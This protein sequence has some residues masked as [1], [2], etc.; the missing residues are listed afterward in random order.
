MLEND[1][2][3]LGK[4]MQIAL[5]KLVLQKVDNP[6]VVGLLIEGTKAS[7]FKMDIAY[8]GQSRMVEPPPRADDIMLV[9]INMEKMLYKF[10][11]IYEAVNVKNI[12]KLDASNYIRYPCGSQVSCTLLIILF[13]FV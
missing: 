11:Y 9:P 12:P 6:V 1:L 7:T 3:K 13:T 2:T 10:N 4:E 8:N 5:N